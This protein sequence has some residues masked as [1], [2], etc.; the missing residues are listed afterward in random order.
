MGS[1]NLYFL[2]K[3]FLYAKGIVVPLWIANLLFIVVLAYPIKRRWLRMVR[4]LIAVLVAMPLIYYESNLPPFM[5][6]FEQFDS[7]KGFT[8]A[9]MQ[10]LLA[11]FL[12]AKVILIG[13]AA[14]LAYS[15]LNRWIRISSFLL[16]AFLATPLWNMASQLSF[17]GVGADG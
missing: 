9:Y 3:L 7:L 6:V 5:R 16:I 14:L 13:L 1:W 12:P 15:V 8:P 4:S 10:E 17:G 2:L 11:R